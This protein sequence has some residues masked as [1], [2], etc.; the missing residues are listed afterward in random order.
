MG[1]EAKNPVK[2][3]R[4]SFDVLEVLYEMDNARLTDIADALDLPDSTVHNHLSTLV[5]C[6]FV[7][8]D[9]ETYRI[10]LRFLTFG[11]F[12]RSR[13]KISDVCRRELADLANETSESASA[14]VTEDGLGYVLAHEPGD[15]SLPIDLY[16]GKQIPLHATS[17]G[18]VIL[19]ELPDETVD[20]IVDRHG[21]AP[22]TSET[23]TD[24]TVLFDELA[25]IRSQ[26]Y[27]V[28]DEE[29][30]RGVR[31]LSMAVRNEGG[32]AVGAIG[33]TGPT[34]RLT[35]DRLH[36]SLLDILT[37]TKN[38]IELKLTYS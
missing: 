18:K 27:A 12:A 21:M 15:T 36:G 29:R 30:L 16:P 31:S 28:G 20:E 24:Q 37:H 5:E 6:G 3:T 33:I 7:T 13:Y 1:H 4:R 17:F 19:A 9:E 22:C 34:S 26:G 10:S 32:V 14:V 23:I 35:Q 38:V 2:A 25:T 8:K 11:E